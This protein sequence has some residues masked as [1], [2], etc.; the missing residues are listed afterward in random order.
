VIGLIASAVFGID[1]GVL[2]NMADREYA[3]G[4]IT[5]L[6]AVVTIGTALVLVVSALMGQGDVASERQF[7]HGKEILSLLLGVFGT[8]VGYYFGSTFPTAGSQ[9]GLRISS[10]ELTPHPAKNGTIVS[11]HATIDGGE[12][13]Y[14]YSIDVSGRVVDKAD[15]V[16]ENGVISKDIDVD[17]QPDDQ[18]LPIRLTVVDMRNRKVAV[19]GSIAILHR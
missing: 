1:R 2:T 4:L 14:H 3:R 6:F 17:P 15:N 18:S 5:F 16:S 12:A 19:S 11:T 7:Q 8:I 9:T 13:P 10:W